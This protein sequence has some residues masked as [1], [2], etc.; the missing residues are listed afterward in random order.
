M[1]VIRR[2][3]TGLI[4]EADVFQENSKNYVSFKRHVN[5]ICQSLTFNNKLILSMAG[6][7]VIGSFTA[8][9]AVVCFVQ[10]H[11]GEL[12]SFNNHSVQVW[13]LSSIFSPEYWVWPDETLIFSFLLKTQF[14]F[15]SLMGHSPKKDISHTLK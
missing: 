1:M 7:K 8:V 2:L 6:A 14:I 4:S 15:F 3:E 9:G 10:S 13:Q 5:V 12:S 11:E